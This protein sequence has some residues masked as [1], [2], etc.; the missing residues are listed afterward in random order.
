MPRVRRSFFVWAAVLALAPGLA[1]QEDLDDLLDREYVTQWLVCGPFAPESPGAMQGA[2][3]ENAALLPERDLLSAAGGAARIRPRHGMPIPTPEGQAIWQSAEAQGHTLD[4][5]PFFPVAA[6][7]IA[8]AGFYVRSPAVQD[9][10]FDLQTPLG[11]RIWLNGQLIREHAPVPFRSAGVDRFVVPFLRGDNFVLLQL[12]GLR[13]EA[14]AETLGAS[15]REVAS[16]GFANRPM[17]AGNSGFEFALALRRT[18]VMGGVAY[19]PRLLPTGGFSGRA[20]AL[21][22]DAELILFNFRAEASPPLEV[23]VRASG[24]APVQLELPPIAPGEEQRARLEVPIGGTPPGGQALAAVVLRAGGDEASFNAPM[25][26]GE[27]DAEGRVRL[28][29]GRPVPQ[30]GLSPG[31]AGAA[32]AAALARHARLLATDPAYGFDLGPASVWLPALMANPADWR[33]LRDA[34]ALGRVGA[35]LQYAPVDERLACE[36]LLARNLDLGMR[37]AR[38]WLGDVRLA[39]RAGAGS[40][41]APQ[42]PQLAQRAGAPG[43][44]TEAAAPGLAPL[45][46]HHGLAGPPLPHRRIDAVSEARSLADLREAVNRQRRALLR[47]GIASDILV[48]H[49]ESPPAPYLLDAAATLRRAVPAILLDGGGAS[50]FFEEIARLP[51]D[52]ARGIPAE[53]RLM[54]QARP[55]EAVAQSERKWLH[56]ALTA[57]LTAAERLATFAAL[58]G[59]RYPGEAIEAAW[60][61][62]LHWAGPDSLG[63]EEDGRR[64]ASA[65]AALRGAFE[66]AESIRQSAARYL[67]ERVSTAR[68]PVPALEGALALVVFNMESHARTSPCVVDVD[69]PGFAGLTLR[70]GDGAALPFRAERVRQ[71]D[72]RL[73]GARIAFVAEEVP[74]FGW[75][76][77]YLSPGGALP[78]PVRNRDLQIENA[79]FR[80]HFDGESGDIVRIL[81]KASG[82]IFAGGPMNSVVALEQAAPQRDG[83]REIW[84]QDAAASS[85]A[86]AASSIETEITAATQ[87]VT[88]VT[89]FLGGQLVRRVALHRNLR[90]IDCELRFEGAEVGGRLLAARF[91]GGAKGQRLMAGERFGA[92]FG[93]TGQASLRYQS[94]GLRHAAVQPA[95]HW[96]ALGPAGGIEIG[97]DGAISL[98]PCQIIPGDHPALFES[99]NELA[100]ALIR[101]GVPASVYPDRPRHGPDPW[102]G[103]TRFRE[104]GEELALGQGFRILIGGPEHNSHA[105]RM[106]RALPDAGLEPAARR[107]AQPAALFLHDAAAPEEFAPPP[108]L[109]LAGA[110]AAQS[111]E[112]VRR[113]AS[114]WE[115][116]GA[117]ALPPAAVLDGA[118]VDA[119]PAIGLAILFEGVQVV[120]TDPGGSL[121]L[122]LDHGGEPARHADLY[123]KPPPPVFRYAILPF[124]GDWRTARLPMAGR[125]FNHPLTGALTV[126]HGGPWPGTGGF[127]EMGSPDFLVTALK[128]ADWPDHD[129]RDRNPRDGIFLRGYAALGS[130]AEGGLAASFPIRTAALAGAMEQPGAPLE[131]TGERVAFS[132]APF[133]IL[134][135]HLA[136]G[137]RIPQGPPQT[138]APEAPAAPSLDSGWPRHAGGAPPPGAD[139]FVLSLHG[140]P[141]AGSIT[142]VAANPD[143]DATIEGVVYLSVPEGWRAGPAQF[144]FQLAPGAHAEHEILLLRDEEGGGEGGLARG[145][146]AAAHAE[147]GGVRHRAVL[148]ADEAPFSL[149]LERSGAQLRARVENRG[150]IP[151]EG[152]LELAV[153]APYWPELAEDPARAAGPRALPVAL[154]PF[155]GETHLFRVGEDV[156]GDAVTVKLSGHGHV[157]YAAL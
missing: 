24:A 94:A 83:G 150:G 18:E 97:L 104:P 46:W 125:D 147:V 95:L 59:A 12:P 44:L 3:A 45:F 124:A 68:G 2:L 107:L 137:A 40:A 93:R 27:A 98:M 89:P 100:A 36:E 101:R 105:A 20:G 127:M 35:H 149:Q 31:E 129:A 134:G 26:V 60:L 61:Q 109:L 121:T 155:R 65:R 132:A 22:Q 78:A 69:L 15:L 79:H 92:V 146:A 33:A 111:V 72:G 9:V 75:R 62:A 38:R 145:G 130:A 41:I 70:D 139:R 74:G 87:Q 28:I 30:A 141:S 82:E 71:R 112:A 117:A 58:L 114:D 103:G 106:L 120:G 122:L 29:T 25:R 4:L 37:F 152:L 156:P 123:P 91:H 67:A 13:L 42:T 142:A 126:Q 51:V 148:H 116:L 43:L 17:L 11:A 115:L 77:Y 21:R 88:V 143:G 19:V 7:G 135:I 86:I 23:E 64:A 144:Y 48:H 76:T 53:G 108:T 81:D 84:T 99:A 47:A 66:D 39:Y 119:A 157:V 153:P 56:H 16:Q 10:Y 8:Y 90:R 34:A 133:E 154:P 85:N 151:L 110:D 50:E 131:L 14:L 118:E 52:A 6:E 55:G 140:E 102:S 54:T 1:A 63:F 32:E 49:A 5:A 138:L 96:A 57:R 113:F 80:V 136:P 73:N 128:P